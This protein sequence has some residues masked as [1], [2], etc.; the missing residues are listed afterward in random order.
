LIPYISWSTITADLLFAVYSLIF[1]A[2]QMF[3]YFL[4][5]VILRLIVS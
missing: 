2:S 1:I 3:V 5:N 4:F